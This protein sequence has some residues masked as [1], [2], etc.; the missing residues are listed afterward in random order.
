MGK[1]EKAWCGLVGRQARATLR[2]ALKHPTRA[3]DVKSAVEHVQGCKACHGKIGSAIENNPD[4]T[5]Y[6]STVE[7]TLVQAR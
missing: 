5:V 4:Q 2:G 1:K 7:A 6:Q 3:W